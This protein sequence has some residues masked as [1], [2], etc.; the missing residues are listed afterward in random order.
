MHGTSRLLIR[1]SHILASR[2]T[3]I[4]QEKKNKKNGRK[5]TFCV[6]GAKESFSASFTILTTTSMSSPGGSL[7]IVC[8]AKKAHAST[9][10]RE[11][12]VTN[13]WAF[14]SSILIV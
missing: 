6:C 2:R 13:I 14:S 4:S 9:V 5:D 10:R 12:T 3:M 11:G 1:A 7:V 8:D